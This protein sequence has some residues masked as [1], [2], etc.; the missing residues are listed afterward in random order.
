M[1]AQVFVWVPVAI[2]AGGVQDHVEE[3]VQ[4]VVVAVAG[5]GV[6]VEALVLGAA[7]MLA[8]VD[9]WERVGPIALV[10]A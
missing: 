2:L 8:V 9:A 10:T 6:L 7:R 1:L 3:T 5:A 4:D